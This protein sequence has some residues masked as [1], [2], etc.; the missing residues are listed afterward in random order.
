MLP[1]PLARF[2]QI[3]MARVI[4]GVPV[5]ERNLWLATEFERRLKTTGFG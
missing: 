2:Q 3:F 5:K 4:L 1:L